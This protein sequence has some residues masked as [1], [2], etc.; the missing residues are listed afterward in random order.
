LPLPSMIDP[1]QLTVTLRENV[2]MLLSCLRPD[3]PA[4]HQ[5]R[6]LV[7]SVSVRAAR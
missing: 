2:A 5:R 3:A 4:A 7:I 1:S 6:R